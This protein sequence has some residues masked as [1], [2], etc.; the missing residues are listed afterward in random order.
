MIVLGRSAVKE[1][2]PYSCRRLELKIN[3]ARQIN[4]EHQPRHSFFKLDHYRPCRVYVLLISCTV[5][6]RLTGTSPKLNSHRGSLQLIQ[7]FPLTCLAILSSWVRPGL[8]RYH[9]LCGA[10]LGT[11]ITLIIKLKQ[12][13]TGDC[14][15][16]HQEV[17]WC[18][19]IVLWVVSKRSLRRKTL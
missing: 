19:S 12:S 4:Q 5:N 10:V 13:C 6:C 3:I 15:A 8:S 7:S 14:L 9:L 17:P 11:L 1:W 2:R 16:V 18:I